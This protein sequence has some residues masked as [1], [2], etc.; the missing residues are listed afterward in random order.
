MTDKKTWS[1]TIQNYVKQEFGIIKMPDGYTLEDLY[2]ISGGFID[3][4]DLD[5]W[6]DDEN[7]ENVE[8]YVMAMT[9]PDWA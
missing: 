8:V 4:E 7:V 1:Q 5:E 9:K 2:T 6:C 3:W